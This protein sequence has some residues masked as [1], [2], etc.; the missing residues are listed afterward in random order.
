[1]TL[2]EKSTDISV[3]RGVHFRGVWGSPD[4]GEFF[5]NRKTQFQIQLQIFF[6]LDLDSVIK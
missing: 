6:F 4:V 5:L 1:M 2:S 3:S